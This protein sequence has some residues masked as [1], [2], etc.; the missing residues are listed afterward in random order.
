MNVDINFEKHQSSLQKY[1][2]P[3]Q[4]SRVKEVVVT[5]LVGWIPRP[6]GTVL[7][8]LMYR[9][10]LARMGKSLY[11]QTGVELI[12]A[13]CIEIG[14]HVKILRDVRLNAFA[15]NSKICLGNRV[16]LDRGV[17]INLVTDEGNCY[18]EIGEWTYLGPYSCMAGPG[19]IKIGKSCLIA[20]HTGIYANN[21]SFADPTRY[22]WEQGITRKGIVIEDD[23]WLGTGVKVLD[24]VTIGQGSVVGAGAVVTKDIPPYSVAVGIP[25]KVIAQRNNK[26]GLETNLSNSKPSLKCEK[27]DDIQ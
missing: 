6:L 19:H 14:D 1:Q 4:W 26:T 23:C 8:R 2:S 3:S 25:S 15:P 5:T 10:I 11:I 16:C 18:V 24:G 27:T 12:N 7:R 21:H 22:I 9:T 13:S 20:S 17:D